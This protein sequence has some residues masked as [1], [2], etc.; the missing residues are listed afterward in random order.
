[1]AADMEGNLHVT[2]T[3]ARNCL[4]RV[5]ACTGEKQ[6]VSRQK[7]TQVS[8]RIAARGNLRGE[9]ALEIIS[10]GDRAGPPCVLPP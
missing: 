1:M 6:I 8:E 4:G 9:E 2:P 3:A 7:A 10:D 5:G